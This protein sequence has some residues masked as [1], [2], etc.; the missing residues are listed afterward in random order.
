MRKYVAMFDKNGNYY[1]TVIAFV[2]GK[3]GIVDE[4]SGEREDLTVEQV[5][6]MKLQIKIVS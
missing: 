6:K 3:F 1:G 5:A 4:Q 2:V